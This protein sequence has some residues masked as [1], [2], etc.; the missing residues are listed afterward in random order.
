[1]LC[2]IWGF[3]GSDYEECR[4]LGY[5][6]EVRTSQETH[7]FSATW[8]SRLMLCNIWGFHGSDC[9]EWRL[10]GYRNLIRTSQETP[11][12][13]AKEH[14]RLR[15]S[16]PLPWRMSSSVMLSLVALLRTDVSEEHIAL[17]ISVA[18]IRELGNLATTSN[19]STPRRNALYY[20]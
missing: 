13:S 2:N 1:M 11:H 10:L 17:I 18:R 19:W 3:H 7:Y 20:S 9:E 14:G 15:F 16:R 4:V 6:N 8:P 5:K 12:F